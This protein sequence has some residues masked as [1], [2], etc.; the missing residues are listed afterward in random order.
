MPVGPAPTGSPPDRQEPLD[1]RG[2][3]LMLD[4]LFVGVTIL[5]FAVLALIVKGVE[6]L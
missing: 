5:V 4:V 1:S 6:K 3:T 2:V